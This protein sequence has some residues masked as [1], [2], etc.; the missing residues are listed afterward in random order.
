MKLFLD[1]ANLK[2]IK[3]IAALGLLD[4]ITTNPS[5]L[6]KE[7]KVEPK[8]HLQ[9]ICKM[10][11]GPVSMEVFATDFEGMVKEGREYSKWAENIV[12]KVPLTADGLRAVQALKAEGIPTNVTLVFS[13][14]QALLAAKAGAAM[15]SPFI[16]RLDEAGQD[17]MT[18]VAE[19]MEIFY[20]YGFETEVLVASV[21]H[22]RHVTEAA[23]L[24]AHIAT[25][26][27]DIFKKLVGHPLTTAGLEKFA[28]DWKQRK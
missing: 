8:K 6:A 15:V 24:G 27:Y 7:G 20:N 19:I 16:G 10:V 5:L 22:P 25:L 1:T 18:V 28:A 13:A 3:E 14:N 23:Q 9:A 17:G 12:V 26:N 11:N 21:R 4:G 2:E